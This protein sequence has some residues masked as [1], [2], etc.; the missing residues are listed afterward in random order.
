MESQDYEHYRNLTLMFFFEK[1]LEKGGKIVF[2]YYKWYGMFFFTCPK[3]LFDNNYL[4][5]I[6]YGSSIQGHTTVLHLCR[7]CVFCIL[8]KYVEMPKAKH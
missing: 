3:W 1:L 7:F 2:F 5:K 8:Q 6:E 4:T